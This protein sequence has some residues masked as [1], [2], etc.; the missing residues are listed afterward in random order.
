MHS[1]S[2]YRKFL[3]T[4]SLVAI[5]TLAVMNLNCSGPSEHA[6]KSRVVKLVGGRGS[7]SGEQVR[8]P[9]G[10]SY[11]LTAGHC[12]ALAKS[13]GS[14]TVITESGLALERR[15]LAEDPSSDLLLLEGLPDVR[16]LDIASANH[17]DQHVRTFTHGGGRATYQTDGRLI[18]D[19]KIQILESIVIPGEAPAPCDGGKHRVV[20][21][22]TFFGGVQAC[23]LDVTETVTTAFIVPGSSGGVVVDDSGELV[24]VVSAG[25]DGFGYLVTLADVHTFLKGY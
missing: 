5:A 3:T 2:M 10:V 22:P 1:K 17:S 6:I 8:A 13:N 20:D 14:I 12:G 15:V 9:S 19:E 18:Q 23:I 21:L 7:C 24:G 11:I 16:G 4:A 25:G